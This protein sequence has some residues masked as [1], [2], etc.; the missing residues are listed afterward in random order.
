MQAQLIDYVV[1]ISEPYVLAGVQERYELQTNAE[2]LVE[3]WLPPGA[4]LSVHCLPK[5]QGNARGDTRRFEA[6][7][8]QRTVPVS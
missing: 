6:F 4:I 5:T 2:G 8:A 3:A 1:E 7:E